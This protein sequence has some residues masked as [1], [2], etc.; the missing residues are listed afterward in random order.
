[1]TPAP[2]SETPS[3]ATSYPEDDPITKVL[4]EAHAI[5]AGMTF[6]GIS[7][8]PSPREN[9]MVRIETALRLRKNELK[10]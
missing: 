1:M 5:L 7:A 10:P 8:S 2:D 6:K 9:A 4:L 3:A